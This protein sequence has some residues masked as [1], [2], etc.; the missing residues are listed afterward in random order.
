MKSTVRLHASL[1]GV[2]CKF[3][4]TACWSWRQDNGMSWRKKVGIYWR[5]GQVAGVQTTASGLL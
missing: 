1:A 5:C 4:G 2:A 3:P